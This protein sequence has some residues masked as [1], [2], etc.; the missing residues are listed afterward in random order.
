MHELWRLQHALTKQLKH[1]NEHYN[2]MSQQHRNRHTMHHNVFATPGVNRCHSNWWHDKS[3]HVHCGHRVA[4]NH[5]P[6][7]QKR[8]LKPTPKISIAQTLPQ[9]FKRL[10]LIHRNGKRK[11]TEHPILNPYTKLSPSE[12][13]RSVQYRNRF[14]P[15]QCQ[16]K[17]QKSCTSII[18]GG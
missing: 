9:K 16:S 3:N 13:H 10:F 14:C 18:L 1:F 6:S 4:P 12:N 11:R 8:T 17:C 2:N 7:K 5:R 15:V